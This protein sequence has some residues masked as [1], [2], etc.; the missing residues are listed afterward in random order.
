MKHVVLNIFTI[1]KLV[2]YQ[3]LRRVQVSMMVK[4]LDGTFAQN[5]EGDQTTFNGK[6]KLCDCSIY[7]Y[8]LENGLGV[9]NISSCYTITPVMVWNG[10]MNYVSS[11]AHFDFKFSFIVKYLRRVLNKQPREHVALSLRGVIFETPPWPQVIRRKGS[12]HCTVPE[13]GR[14]IVNMSVVKSPPLGS[15]VK[16]APQLSS[17]IQILSEFSSFISSSASADRG[18]PSSSTRPCPPL[19]HPH[20]RFFF[21]NTLI[22]IICFHVRSWRSSVIIYELCGNIKP[23]RK[24]LPNPSAVVEGWILKILAPPHHLGVIQCWVG[25]RRFPGI[26]QILFAE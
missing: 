13:G 9:R 22:I 4:P 12:P 8:T 7:F 19:E 20:S 11:S 23:S 6:T 3:L 10:F 2:L 5:Y 14:S 1:T 21:P 18:P 26:V 15:K 24:S 25:T 16:K 17:P